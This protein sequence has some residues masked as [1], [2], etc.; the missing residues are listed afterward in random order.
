MAITK[1]IIGA[2]PIKL[3]VDG[4]ETSAS[5]C[6]IVRTVDS[7]GCNVN[8]SD[9]RACDTVTLT[10]LTCEDTTDKFI[11]GSIPIEGGLTV[12]YEI[13][14]KH[15]DCDNSGE[16]ECSCKPLKTWTIPYYVDEGYDGDIEFYYEYYHISAGTDTI[17]GKEKRIGHKTITT[18]DVG[19]QITILEG[20]DGCVVTAQTGNTIIGCQSEAGTTVKVSFSVS[21]SE[22]PGSGATVSVICNFK[23]ITIDTECN[24][25]VKTGTFSLTKTVPP[26]SG[27]PDKG[28]C[29]QHDAEITISLSEIRSVVGNFDIYYNNEKVTDDIKVTV[30]QNPLH[31]EECTGICETVTS[32]CVDQNTVKILYEK[33]YGYGGIDETEE[34]GW[35]ENGI[36]PYTGGRIRVVWTYSAFTFTSMCTENVNKL[37]YDEI[38]SIGGCDESTRPNSYDILFKKQ[39]SACTCPYEY[40]WDEVEQKNV[41]YNLITIRPTQEPCDGGGGGGDDCDSFH[42]LINYSTGGCSDFNPDINYS[43]GGCSDFNP[44]I[45]YGV[46]GNITP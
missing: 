9:E 45:E 33:V 10:P 42:P 8:Y 34:D 3:E 14:Q 43:T 23:K 35:T 40:L 32:Y 44:D 13:T 12:N 18:G 5:I 46:G 30:K 19:T 6:W 21:P 38:M 11:A 31:T 2:N 29:Y 1:K 41:K 24:E 22:V 26:C 27:L 36:V 4:R 25:T 16:C 7:D 28:C 20:C 39:Y 37:Q 17:C 15:F